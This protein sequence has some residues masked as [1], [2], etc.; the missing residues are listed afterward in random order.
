MTD[1]KNIVPGPDN[2]VELFQSATKKYS[3]NRLF[4]TKNKAKT[5]YD[6]VT[7]G[8]VTKRIDNLRGGLAQI[9]V[10]KGDG[11]AIIAN[12][13]VSW[14]VA[15]YATYGRCARFIPMYEA[16]L[17]R[18][19]KYIITDS[20][21]KILLVANMEIYE[22]VKS[23]TREIEALEAIYVI[24]GE[25]E[26][27]MAALEELG[28]KNP[29]EAVVPQGSDIAGLIYTSGTTGNPK[30]VLLSHLNLAS[31]VV[32]IS[33]SFPGLNENVRTLSFLPWAH[34]FGQVAELH[35]LVYF[36]G[37]TGFAESPATIVDDLQLVKPTM[38]VAVP[39]IF[40]KVYAGLHTK[41][42]E[43]GGLA[44]ALFD[45]G[46][47]AGAKERAA[48]G[49]AG[50]VNSLKKAVADKIVFSKIRQKFGGQ[51]DLAVSSSAAL[52][53]KIAEFFGDIGIPVYEAWGMT[54][55]S[56]AHT[57]NSPAANRP[58]TV[59]RAILGSRVEI[60]KSMT[61]P[62][63]DDGEIIAYGP[64]VM[65]GYHNLPEETRAVLRSDGGLAT[66]DR[67]RLD[68]DGYVYITGRIKE[69]YKLENGKYVFP[70]AIEE[71][72]K[73]SPYIENCMIYGANK[74]FNVALVVPDFAVLEPWA[75]ENG[76]PADDH[77]ALVEEEKVQDLYTAEIKKAC[78]EFAGYETPKKIHIIA[79]EFSTEN[80]ILT[81]TLKLKRRV[82]LERYGKILEALYEK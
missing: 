74:V 18:I 20:G 44:K 35:L 64:N 2:L 56:P 77:K 82:I 22:K 7:Y 52:S 8:E 76:L 21:S 45:M 40:S 46:L 42:T 16:E 31:N 24:D 41:I 26:M 28:A 27:T 70:V 67:G 78:A 25:G 19:W 54:E 39:R 55:L 43:Q 71:S 80:G 49:S 50:L 10:D 37:S 68:A 69:Q 6:W 51:L 3:A 1:S 13:R 17:T 23:F 58:G 53:Q 57:L 30:G 62:D 79:E 48:G 34:S 65:V 32:A 12:N 81:P 59:G 11:V 15:A 9:G 73:L 75:K 4:G 61:G 66:G 63:S 29:V 36:G 47:A 38:L 60:D 33:S 5:G 14:A 72:I